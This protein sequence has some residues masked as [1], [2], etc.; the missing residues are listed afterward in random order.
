M[1]V[2]L[3]LLETKIRWL[4]PPASLL[5]GHC[6][7]WFSL[8]PEIKTGTEIMPFLHHWWPKK[9]FVKCIGRDYTI[10][11]PL[12]VKAY[13]FSNFLNCFVGHHI[14]RKFIERRK[15][16]IVLAFSNHYRKQSIWLCP[17]SDKSFLFTC[18]GEFYLYSA[19]I[20]QKL[21][22][23]ALVRLLRWN[24]CRASPFCFILY[25]QTEIASELDYENGSRPMHRVSPSR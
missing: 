12:K 3:W 24:I 22:L 23:G 15:I 21:V 10:I 13:S 20:I 17:I 6:S 2:C 8:I 7:M 1:D 14:G 25:C 4:F 9:N 5:P 11:V 19:A 16:L 18:R